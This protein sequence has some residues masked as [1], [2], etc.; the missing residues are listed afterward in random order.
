MESY[1]DTIG[2]ASGDLSGPGPGF[3]NTI[4]ANTQHDAGAGLQWNLTIPPNGSV[5]V[6]DT[7]LF[8]PHS[9]LCGSFSDVPYGRFNYEYIY[10][11]PCHGIVGG[12]GDTTFRPNNP[13]TRG[14]LSKMV[15]NSAGWLEDHTEQTFEDVPPGSTFYIWIQRIAS[16]GY[17]GGYPCGGPFEPCGPG[18]R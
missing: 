8:S 12:Y 16:R 10:Y 5:T 1:Y 7:D 14:Q 17:I 2:D 6:G 9:S 3:D 15:S 13:I 11:L 18:N 4:I